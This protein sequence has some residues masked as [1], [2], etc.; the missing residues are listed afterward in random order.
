[1]KR[2][3][4]PAAH[5]SYTDASM[6]VVRILG[7]DNCVLVGGLAVAAYGHQRATKDVD[8]ITRLPLHEARRR[9]AAD[10]L[11]TE[12][13]EGDPCE[14]VPSVLRTTV[15]G[16]TVDIL[17]MLV[18]FDWEQLADVF[19]TPAASLKVIDL[20]T[21][22]LL[23]TRAG[24]VQDMLDVAHLVWRNPE[25]LTLARE[26]ASRY[27]VGDKLE[28]CLNDRREQRKFVETLPSARRRHALEELG[29]LLS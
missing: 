7:A 27:A 10:G 21:L 11:K 15:A 1:M 20:D 2:R 25:R 9:L 22:L 24:G 29:R 19:L 8:F 14:D 6:R 4:S 18:R 23:K 26:L 12:L 3:R 5:P 16:V 17:P 28:R 13:R